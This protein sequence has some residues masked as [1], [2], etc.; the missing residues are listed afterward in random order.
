[1]NPIGRSVRATVAGLS[2]LLG[3]L[4]A[5]LP[6]AAA[7][8]QDHARIIENLPPPERQAYV[9]RLVA[10]Q[11]A[12]ASESLAVDVTGP[13]LTAFNS[14]TSLNLGKSAT[15]FK[16]A[17]KATDELSGVTGAYFYAY[18]PS[19]QSLYVSANV[20]FPLTSFNTPA[21]VSSSVSRL[22]E[23]GTWTFTYG[24]VYDAAGNYS[25]VDQAA[26][27]ALG[28]ATFTVVNNG[29]Y[30]IVKPTLVDGKILTP[31]VSLSSILPGTTAE[32]PYV[33]IKV[34]AADTGNSAL[35]GVRQVQLY[36]CKVAKPDVCIYPYGRTQAT[37]QAAM[38]LYVGQQVSAAKGNLT[39]T[40]EL[41]TIYIYDQAQNYTYLL[42]TLFGGTTDFSTMFPSGTKIKLTP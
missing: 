40:Y 17:V 15:P 29:G 16:V 30:D 12:R 8:A 20:G 4:F 7:D 11:Q 31:T 28:S 6:A 9:Q 5:T 21:G 39:G 13:V 27:E 26:L 24:Y 33:Q 10:L 14:P 38:S 22:L 25:Y 37:G 1:M 19:G 18:G 36:F 2:A 23:P 34:N 35:S 3:A 42:G 32:P 41:K